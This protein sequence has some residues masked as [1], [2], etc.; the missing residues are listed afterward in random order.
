MGGDADQRSE[1][2][3]G[4]ARSL[5]LLTSS[6]TFT[7][8]VGTMG[9]AFRSFLDRDVQTLMWSSRHNIKR[10]AT[11]HVATR[12][13][14]IPSCTAYSLLEPT[15]P[16]LSHVIPRFDLTFARGPMEN[17]RRWPVPTNMTALEPRKGSCSV[18]PSRFLVQALTDH[19]GLGLNT[20]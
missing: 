2:E 1:G 6:S 14:L 13:P 4:C 8:L 19:R 18:I 15:C 20:R 17:P 10:Q 16:T 5:I 3:V 11:S 12:P 7:H 9:F